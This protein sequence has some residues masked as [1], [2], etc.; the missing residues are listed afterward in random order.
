[1]NQR[2]MRLRRSYE[3]TLDRAGLALA[4]GGLLG[5][6]LVLGLVLMGG[7]R[8]PLALA[9]AF[10]IGTICVAL[11]LTAVVTP[12][13]LV[14]HAAGWRRPSHAALVGAVTA[15]VLFVGGQTYGF[16]LFAMPATDSQTLLYRWASAF[17]TAAIL[18]G[19]AAVIGLVMW[20]IAYRRSI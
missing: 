20:R 6:G 16:G 12:I 7:Q 11:A 10:V 18:A 9:G 2:V 5:G 4:T 15:L 14:M 1:M 3:T 19:A 13:W 17:A 8:A